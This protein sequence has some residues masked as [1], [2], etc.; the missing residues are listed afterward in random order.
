MCYKLLNDLDFFRWNKP[1][2]LELRIFRNIVK[3]ELRNYFEN[4]SEKPVI[5]R[6][7]L[8]LKS[9]DVSLLI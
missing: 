2:G 4:S 8:T 1:T 3:T 6:V 7:S 5:G 9:G